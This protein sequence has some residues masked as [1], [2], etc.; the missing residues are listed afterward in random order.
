MKHI[1]LLLFVGFFVLLSGC[2]PLVR[3]LN[4]CLASKIVEETFWTED[5]K[6]ARLQVY[7]KVKLNHRDVNSIL[8]LE[9]YDWT[10]CSYMC[11][12]YIDDERMVLKRINGFVELYEFEV[13]DI[14]KYM[15]EKMKNNDY[16]SLRVKSKK[17]RTTSG[18]KFVLTKATKKDKSWHVRTEIISAFVMD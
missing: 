16:V 5:I 17:T 10:Q 1:R 3:K 9:Y 8:V 14:E 4:V 18:T 7:R 12:L 15:V 11:I 13:F 2:S 6:A